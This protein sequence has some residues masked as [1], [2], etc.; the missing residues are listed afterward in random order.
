MR[1]LPAPCNSRQN[2]KES[3]GVVTS[4]GRT[5]VALLRLDWAIPWTPLLISTET[6]TFGNKTTQDHTSR[7][8]HLQTEANTSKSAKLRKVC[9]YSQTSNKQPPPI[10]VYL[11]IM[12]TLTGNFFVRTNFG[13]NKRKQMPSVRSVQRFQSWWPLTFSPKS[14]PIVL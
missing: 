10:R 3:Q 4:R 14:V 9:I 12:A 6:H 5:T 8:Q 2:T 1:R 11:P 13:E 7:P